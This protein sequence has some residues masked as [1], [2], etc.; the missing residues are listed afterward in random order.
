MAYKIWV[1]AASTA[2]SVTL[3][4]RAGAVPLND[5]NIEYSQDNSKWTYI[6][7]PLNSTSCTQ[8]S[9]VSISSGIIYIRAINDSNNVQVYGR[10]SNS[11]TCPANA[12]FGCTYSAVITGTE[13][14]A[15]TVYVDG[16][17]DFQ[18]CEV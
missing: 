1:G 12:A 9:T 11:S 8:L 7:G 2:Y 16:N 5:Y 6:A 3:Y 14:V 15:F 13:D 10:G 4:S 17:G 18:S